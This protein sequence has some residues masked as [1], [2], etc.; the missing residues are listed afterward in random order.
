M[1]IFDAFSA[2]PGQQA[3]ADQVTALNQG[4]QDLQANYAAGNQALTTNYANALAPYTT[5]FNV[6]NQGQDSLADALG[7]NGPAGSARA[8]AAFQANPGYQFQQQQG[9]NAVLANQARTGQTASGNTDLAL[10]QQ[11]QNIANQGWNSYIGNL[12]PFLGAA[13]SA[14]GGI[15]GVDT[16]LGN[17]LNANYTG[18]GQNLAGLDTAT[19]KAQAGGDMAGYNASSN[20]IGAGLGL[21]GDVAKLGGGGAGGSLASSLFGK[22]LAPAQANVPAPA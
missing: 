8:T 22:F 4:K 17:A 19:G 1:G 12:Q 20:L 11:G 15:A 10:Q 3:A 2:G 9:A 13:N 16:G 7:L 21:A 5:N 6:A 14:A 18:L